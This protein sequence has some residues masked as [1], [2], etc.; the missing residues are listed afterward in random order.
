[1]PTTH[2]AHC[3]QC[4]RAAASATSSTATSSTAT[5]STAARAKAGNERVVIE[6]GV[7]SL[8]EQDRIGKA[9]GHFGTANGL[10]ITA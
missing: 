2:N 4:R 8:S 3:A 9:V 6:V 7:I 1:M 10:P 5:S